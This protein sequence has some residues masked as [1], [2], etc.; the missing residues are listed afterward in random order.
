MN[1]SVSV[2]SAIKTN[3][4]DLLNELLEKDDPKPDLFELSPDGQRL[5]FPLENNTLHAAAGKLT[6]DLK[7]FTALLNYAMRNYNEEYFNRYLNSQNSKGETPLYLASRSG[8]WGETVQLLLSFKGIDL[9]LADNDGDTPLHVSIYNDFNDVSVL[10]IHAGARFDIANKEGETA[11][12][13]SKTSDKYI[14]R[15]IQGEITKNKEEHLATVMDITKGNRERR[16]K[17]KQKSR[18]ES[19]SQTRGESRFT[20]TRFHPYARTKKKKKKQKEKQKEKE[21]KKKQK[22]VELSIFS[23]FWLL[24]SP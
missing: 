3:N 5:N 17:T 15:L 4:L 8:G 13:L 14:H 19:K 24:A 21:K 7:I 1:H 6:T 16:G 9:N 23:I 2:F 18:R 22:T 10:L 12:D 20:K 11:L